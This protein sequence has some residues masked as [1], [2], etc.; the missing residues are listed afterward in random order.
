S[1][2]L[3]SQNTT[4]TSNTMSTIAS[5]MQNIALA[6]R[7]TMRSSRVLSSS[8][9]LPK[10]SMR[11]CTSATKVFDRLRSD[12]SRLSVW[13]ASSSGLLS[14]S[15]FAA[16]DQAERDP[17][18]HGDAHRVPGM[19]A[20]IAVGGAHRIARM[21]RSL[22]GERAEVQLG[23]VQ[24]LLQLGAPRGG[25]VPDRRAQQRL[26]VGDHQPQ[27]GGELVR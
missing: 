8:T 24:A 20:H 27:V 16:D 3:L 18:E 12:S 21:G 5:P 14:T 23:G 7:T 19:L 6:A 2:R 17:R 13:L 9:S 11:V 1:S 26:G 15:L 10:S 25:R 22:L 4:A